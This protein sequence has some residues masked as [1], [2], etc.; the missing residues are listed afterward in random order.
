MGQI[1]QIQAVEV[2]TGEADS[3]QRFPTV[4]EPS[5]INTLP[6]LSHSVTVSNGTQSNGY[7]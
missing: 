6:V 2:R 5:S 4:L 7:I 3:Q 1:S